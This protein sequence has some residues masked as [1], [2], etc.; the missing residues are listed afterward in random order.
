MLQKFLANDA[1]SY[2]SATT[3]FFRGPSAVSLNS[4]RVL[5]R[6]GPAGTQSF[7][8]SCH[9]VHAGYGIPKIW[10]TLPWREN[11]AVP[12][13]AEPSERSR[14]QRERKDSCSRVGN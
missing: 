4:F 5:L 7:V 3:R 9:H 2:P 11:L 10:A 1:Y 6:K 8:A 14:P 13:R 12:K